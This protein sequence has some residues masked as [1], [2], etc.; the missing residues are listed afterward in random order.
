MARDFRPKAAR[1]AGERKSQTRSDAPT[2]ER[3]ARKPLNSAQRSE[4]TTSDEDEDGLLKEIRAMGGDESD[5][6]LVRRGKG[7]YREKDQDEEEEEEPDLNNEVLSFM[8]GLDFKTAGVEAPKFDVPKTSVKEKKKEDKKVEGTNQKGKSSKKEDAVEKAT[9]T[10]MIDTLKS[11]SSEKT[12][13]DK[14]RD[15]KNNER[16]KKDGKAKRPAE[17]HD[18]ASGANRQT[19]PKPQLQSKSKFLLQPTPRW[20]EAELGALKQYHG[21]SSPTAD[22]MTAL[23]QKGSRLL[24]SEKAM[25]AEMTRSGKGL[26]PGMLSS[27]D[28]RF[29]SEL[30][31]PGA[32][33]GTL[34]DRVAALTLLAQSSPMHNIDAM[35][36]LLNMASK[37][38]REESGKATRALADWLASRGGL[39]QRKLRYFVDNP[40]STQLAYMSRHVSSSS[41]VFSSSSS[42]SEEER[43]LA[44]QHLVLA[45][46][47]DKL[48]RFYFQFLQI[49]ETQTHDTLP[50]VRKQA[51]TQV[52][53]L[54][55]EKSEQEQN[56]LRLLVNKLG[57]T[58]RAVAS[59]ASSSL[60]NILNVHPNMKS[61]ITNE[62]SNL[63]MKPSYN[64][65][66]DGKAKFNSHARYYG[67]LTLN[68][69]MLTSRDESVANR[70]VTFYFELFEN[71]LNEM[72]KK[73]GGKEEAAEEGGEEEADASDKPKKQK[74]R[75]RDGKGTGRGKKGGKA[76]QKMAVQDESKVIL[77]ADSKTMAAIL[78]GV[79][80]ALPFARVDGAIFEKH[81]TT[82]FRI[83]HSSTFNISIQALQLI[84]QVSLSNTAASTSIQG[85]NTSNV[86]DRF[87]R[88]LYASLLDPRLASTSKQAMYLN[89]L[90]KAIKT[91]TDD[92]RVKAFVKRFVQTLNQG[93]PPW[94]CGGLFLLGELLTALPGL[95]ALLQD[96][97]DDGDEHF[98]DAI[99]GSDAVGGSD[100]AAAASAAVKAGVLQGTSYDATKREPQFAKAEDSCLWE[101]TPLLHHFHPSVSLHAHQLLNGEKITTTADL[102][103]N[104]LAHFLD[105]FVYRNPKKVIAQSKGAS[106]MQPAMNAGDGTTGAEGGVV[107][108]KGVGIRQE[109]FV[110]DEK[111]WKKK[112]QEVPVDQLFFH[113]YFTQK[114]SRNG[115]EEDGGEE[116]E[117]GDDESDSEGQDEAAGEDEEDEEDSEAER[118][119]LKEMKRTMPRLPGDE[120]L[121]ESDVD[122]DD[123]DDLIDYEDSD[124]D[125]DADA[126]VAGDGSEEESED[127]FFDEDEDDLLPIAFD[128]SEGSEAEE[129]GGGGRGTKRRAEDEGEEA[130]EKLAEG[131][132]KSKSQAKREERKR[133]KAMPTFASADDYA[134]LLGNSDDEDIE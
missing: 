16:D 106:I 30:L 86:E 104:T 89:L 77:D 102:T 110:N 121:D 88:A 109:E 133:R 17:T 119:I 94:I 99:E 50:F 8:K 132:G 62:V 2:P 70:L 12:T 13:K 22:E 117:S 1:E 76:Q 57:D 92:R 78:A 9:K 54:L 72:N 7:E 6:E 93:E 134:H 41:S 52:Y 103:L 34:S 18:I 65:D 125:D 80:R 67:I 91:D 15:V 64:V 11:T 58:D 61:V 113:K 48:K 32:K 38:G 112:V 42:S 111:F 37:K 3:K 131:M 35:E 123:E 74:Q 126:E 97:E 56:L 45:I 107:K 120:M 43:E 19:L 105:R 127:G 115:G 84:Y 96:P 129:G 4:S 29:I 82:L 73:A 75:W 40:I 27:S 51:V 79:R 95:K 31:G 108:L 5:L 23:Q 128:D 116:G 28:A 68:Q 59:K 118:E 60:L 83:T 47:E 85:M 122:V 44:D 49:L 87:Y 33:G 130:G 26:G 124:E 24:D 53:L 14:A 101:L 46:F 81:M 39:S 21:K 66:S 114:L 25:Y 55:K 36:S 71:V 63:V 100:G 90:F 98:V 20:N 69:T 10:K